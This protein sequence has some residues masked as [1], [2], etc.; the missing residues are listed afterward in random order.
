MRR[1]A[2][3]L[4][5]C[6]S[7]LALPSAAGAQ[8]PVP[9]GAQ[10]QVNT[11]TT[12]DQ[13]APSASMAPDGRFVVAWE[14]IGTG[15]YPGRDVSAQRYASDG[16]TA[17]AEFVV[18]TFGLYP[19]AAASAGAAANGDFVVAW[20]NAFGF[21]PDLSGPSIQLQRFASDGTPLGL[22]F[23]VNSYTTN[24]Q[25]G[26]SV[27]VAPDGDFVVLWTSLGSFGTDMSSDSI[28]GQ[29]YT[30]SGATLGGEFQVNTY[31]TN[32]QSVPSVA[33]AADGDF[34]VVW[35]SYGSANDAGSFSIQG[36]RYASDG[37][38]QGGEFQV[39]T[40]TTGHQTDA[41]VSAG[42]DGDF[43]VAWQSAGSAETDTSGT[44]IQAR[45]YASDGSAQ[46]GEFQVNSYTSD[47]QSL[48]SVAAFSDGS[49][50]VAWGSNGS[51][52]TDTSAAS[53]QA[54]Y[55]A[56]DGAPVGAQFQVNSYTTTGS[57]GDDPGL[58]VQGQRYAVPA[59]V[60]SLSPTGAAAGALLVL[61]AVACA[62]RR[63]V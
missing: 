60:P 32:S 59:A 53:V 45:R 33:S 1:L 2:A 55:Y 54:Q 63:R 9:V 37:S 7:S 8:A 10:F 58:S 26:P 23:Q 21:Y 5:V 19:Q 27:A 48:P 20:T 17:G 46:G 16:S 6:A 4:A 40:Y 11:Y 56:S 47:S 31:T 28:Q 49:F 35:Q 18:N 14:G 34:V 51:A 62:L 15:A 25:S 42:A 39:N 44:S 61:L 36:Q 22:E 38:A 13:V 57:P 41:S 12:G 30:S 3:P 50:A 24:G 29:R 52:G 43:V